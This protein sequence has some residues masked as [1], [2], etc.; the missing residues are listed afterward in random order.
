MSRV[1]RAARNASLMRVETLGN[2]TSTAVGSEKVIA[3]AEAGELYFIDHNHASAL[4]ITLPAMKAGAYFKF[5]WIT[6]MT[7][8]GTVVFNSADNTA[9]D[10]AGSILEVVTGGSDAAS[11][12]Q[13]IGAHD[14][15]T[16]NDDIDPGSWLEVI[17]DGSTW[18]WTGNLS[19]SAVG[20][21]V[22]S[23]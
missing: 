4:T 16:V 15:L 13:A 18:Y 22:S 20:L 9:S 2:G 23:T 10:F 12:F 3:S 19:V 7:A 11:A 21:A 5:L 6:D 1:A 14:I 17:C 8:A